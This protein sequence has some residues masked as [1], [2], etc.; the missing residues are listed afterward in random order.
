MKN[1]IKIALLL[2]C[3]NAF[4][5]V[6]TIT[7]NED[8]KKNVILTEIQDLRGQELNSILIS[9]IER[10]LWNLRIFSTVEVVN[11]DD[12]VKINVKPRWTLIP[13]AKASGGGGSTFYT[14]G[15]Y[16]I[17]TSGRYLE[18]GAQYESLNNRPAGVIWLRKP[19]FMDDRNLKFGMDIWTINRIR[20][21]YKTNGDDNGA[22]SLERK[23]LS[24]FIEKKIQN[25]FYLFGTQFEYKQDHITDFGIGDEQ[26]ELN[27]ANDFTP[28]QKS[29]NKWIGGYF[30]A[31]RVD[32]EN[33]LLNGNQIRLEGN[34]IFSNDGE[35]KVSTD[36]SLKYNH[37]WLF[38]NNQNLAFQFLVSSNNSDQLQDQ[39]FIGGLGEVRGYKDGQFFNQ[40]YW[41]G[42]LE[43]RFDLYE[44]D[45]MILQGAVFSDMAKE[46]ATIQGIGDNSNS[47]LLSSGLGV[48]FISP[49]IFRFVGRLD[50]A[51]THTRFLD[52]S[53]SFGIQQFF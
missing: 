21:L 14:L 16:N 5:F 10:R 2:F 7:G 42:N 25:D 33:Y 28:S 24:L 17:N 19:H 39:K 32:Y 49:K 23:K 46:G 44:K 11:S 31:G 35:E 9:E 6:V 26:V 18:V 52:K 8:T 4:S 53:L 34:L 27:N 37:Y 45:W 1:L 30:S 36:L 48:R 22:Y 38:E 50:Y 20:N 29:I 47:I 12:V 41:Q 51:Q 40:S 43:H 3:S 13:I 15:V